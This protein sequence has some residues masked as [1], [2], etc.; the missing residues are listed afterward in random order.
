M[1]VILHKHHHLLARPEQQQ[2]LVRPR[3]AGHPTR[4]VADVERADDQEMVDAGAFHHAR[5][6]VVPARIF[7][8][9]EARIVLLEGRPQLRRQLECIGR[10]HGRRLR[11]GA[12]G[13]A[14]PRGCRS[15]AQCKLSELTSVHDLLHR[16]MQWPAADETIRLFP[17]SVECRRRIGAQR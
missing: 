9:G 17:M 4:G 14:G 15:G 6:Q 1:V 3:P 13:L 11:Q 8:V 7:R 5:Q 16:S 12:A 2:R 10:R